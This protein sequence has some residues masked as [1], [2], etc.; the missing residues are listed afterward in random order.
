MKTTYIYYP[1][2]PRL[3]VGFM[4][5]PRLAHGQDGKTSVK[6]QNV[7]WTE[8]RECVLLANSC[9]CWINAFTFQACHINIKN[10]KKRWVQ[11]CRWHAFIKNLHNPEKEK[12]GL[13]ISFCVKQTFPFTGARFR[14]FASFSFAFSFFAKFNNR[15]FHLANSSLDQ[16]LFKEFI[17]NVN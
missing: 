6:K 12:S 5:K 1:S 16:D 11:F 4:K 9:L 7:F 17:W 10:Y 13:T 3:K 14:Y 8:R 15:F 2:G